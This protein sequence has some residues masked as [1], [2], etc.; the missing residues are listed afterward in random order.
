MTQFDTEAN[1]A[2]DKFERFVRENAEKYEES[3]FDT[4]LD[5]LADILFD[6]PPK[7]VQDFYAEG[8]RTF[9]TEMKTTVE[10]LADLVDEGLKD[11][12]KIVEDGKAEVA[13]NIDGLGSDLGDFKQQLSDEMNDKFRGLEAKIT[14][15]QGNLIKGIAQRYVK[16]FERVK[17]I[18]NQV[19][20]E[21]KNFLQK[22][23]DAYHAVKDMIVGQIEKLAAIV[24]AA[25]DRI[26]RD[27]GTFLSNLGQGIIQGLTMFISDI[28]ENIKTAV[29]QWLTG[30]LGGAGIPIPTSFDAKGIIGFL[31]DIVGLGITSIKNIARKVLGN[32]VVTLIEKGEAGAEKIKEIFDILSSEGPAGLFRYLQAEFDEM[33]EQILGEVGKAIA[34]SLVI[35]G[36]KKVLGIISGLVSGG[37]GT[38]ITI[39]LT[40]IDVIL[41]FRDNA[42][43]LAELVSTIAGTAMAILQ[44]QVGVVAGAI[45]NLLKRVLPLVLGFVG[46]LIGIGGVVRKI[47][48]IFKAIKKPATKAITALFQKLEE[49]HQEAAGQSEEGKEKEEGQGTHFGASGQPRFEGDDAED[50]SRNAAAALAEKKA[51]AQSLISKYQP[52]LKKGKLKITIIDNSAADVEK[53]SAVDFDVAASPGKKGKA[54]VPIKVDDEGAVRKRFARAR[55]M[56]KFTAEKGF[57]VS[58]W[59][60]TFTKLAAGTHQ[61]DLRFGVTQAIVTKD[62]A[63][64][65][66]SKV[67][68]KEIVAR[69]AAAVQDQGRGHAPFQK[70]RFGV[71][72]IA[73]LPDVQKDCRSAAG[74]LRRCGNGVRRGN[75]RGEG[76]RDQEGREDTDMGASEDSGKTDLPAGWGGATHVRPR[77]YD[78][79]S[80]YPWSGGRRLPKGNSRLVGPEIDSADHEA[81]GSDSLERLKG[82]GTG[83]A[84]RYS[85]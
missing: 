9:L 85:T 36:I 44:G 14:E 24:G 77:Y 43:Q 58:D 26:I 61:K 63:Y 16:A 47:Q 60:G 50:Q 4:A 62:S 22:A 71:P 45:N 11:A 30:N 18:E 12:R 81:Y 37:V 42:A 49:G 7:E 55:S 82:L 1:A 54:P 21:Y 13:T 35:A 72:L 10:G 53:N 52:Q 80:G 17:A 68:K 57:G 83:P 84:K 51:Q 73:D 75:A 15:K 65:F 59:A 70:G 19:R 78:R 38:V 40:I 31:L 8:R 29:V 66:K 2:T 3:W 33:K 76:R 25:A 23:Q 79:G 56:K 74:Q 28:G 64:H 67:S 46:A 6:P 34:E 41:W 69:G 39:V 5:M 20:E 32:A 48:Q 27:P